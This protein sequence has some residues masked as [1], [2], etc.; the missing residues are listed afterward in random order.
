M[1]SQQRKITVMGHNEQDIDAAIREINYQKIEIDVNHDVIDYVC[2]TN[3]S[4]LD[5]F[6][7]KSGVITLTVEPKNDGKN[8][9][10][11]AVGL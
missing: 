3:D 6:I 2:G 1:G 5:Y 4:N 8:Y 10:L 9:K 7:S 11:V